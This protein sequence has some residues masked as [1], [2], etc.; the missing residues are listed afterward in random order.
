[1]QMDRN[2]AALRPRKQIQRKFTDNLPYII[3][4]HLN[5]R[6]ISAKIDLQQAKERLEREKIELQKKTLDT[7]RNV[8][9][10]LSSPGGRGWGYSLI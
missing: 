10:D 3:D 2:F 6:F 9:K 5:Y 1:M 4:T 8:D 7:E